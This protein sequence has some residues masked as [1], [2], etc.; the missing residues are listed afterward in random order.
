MEYSGGV[1]SLVN[2]GFISSNW[3]GVGTSLFAT[4]SFRDIT[5]DQLIMLMDASLNTQ[6]FQ[7]IYRKLTM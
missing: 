6:Q 1:N 2:Q 3:V 5:Q 7:S 4:S